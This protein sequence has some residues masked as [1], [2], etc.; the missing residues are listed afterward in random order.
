MI[1]YLENPK[2]STRKLSELIHEFD[3]V[4]GYKINT[5][6]SMGFLYTNNKRSEREIREA[7]PFSI[8]SKRIKYLGVNLPKET[9]DLSSENYKPLMKEIKDD[10]NRWKD[11]PCSWIGRVNIIK[12][13]LLPKAIYRFNAIPIKLPRTFFTEIRQNIFKFVWKHK[14][15]RIA[16]DILEKKKGTREIRLPDFRL[17]YKSTII[18]TVWYWHKDRQTD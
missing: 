6:K 16:K 14:R 9:K 13:T 18:K 8:A 10:T 2:D 15:P 5:Q 3:K 7:M 17:K 4:A 12:M 11:M 1:L